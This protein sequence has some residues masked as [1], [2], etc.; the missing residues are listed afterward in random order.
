MR[1]IFRHKAF[2]LIELLV[3]ISIIALL[4]A[5]LLPALR[6]ARDSAMSAQCLSQLRQTGLG[7]QMYAQDYNDW[8]P[9][10]YTAANGTWIMPGDIPRSTQGPDWWHRLGGKLVNWGEDKDYPLSTHHPS[11]QWTDRANYISTT[12]VFYCPSYTRLTA[13][14]SWNAEFPVTS[15]SHYVASYYWDFINP[16]DGTLVGNTAKLYEFG[17][18]RLSMNPAAAIVSDFGWPGDQFRYYRWP[19]SHKS[20]INEL[21]LGGHAGTVSKGELDQ[22]HSDYPSESENWWRRLD[23]LRE[24]GG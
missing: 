14:D 20:T 2:T 6:A 12:K 3:V 1:R 18:S 19:P 22:I 11:P 5:I 7:I 21:W 15:G 17:N 24:Q 10:N 16:D 4:I 13:A 9:I 8:T 23:Y